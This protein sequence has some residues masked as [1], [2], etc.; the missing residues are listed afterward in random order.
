[1]NHGHWLHRIFA[2]STTGS[3]IRN[4]KSGLFVQT[5]MDTGE[6]KTDN[7]LGRGDEGEVGAFEDRLRL[8]EMSVP[9]SRMLFLAF[10]L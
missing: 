10:N 5:F 1:M 3:K 6:G 9:P 4:H 2:L 7:G 8:I